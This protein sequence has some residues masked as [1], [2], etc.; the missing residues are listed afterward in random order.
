LWAKHSLSGRVEKENERFSSHFSDAFPPDDDKTNERG[1]MSYTGEWRG[2]FAERL[3]LT[4]GIRRDDNDNFQDFTTWRTAASLVLRELNARPH[5]SAGTAVKLPTMFEQ[6]GTTQFFVPNPSL[7]P[8]KS[9]G[10]DAGVELT[11]HSGRMT[12][13]VTYFRANLTDKINGFFFDPGLGNFTAINLPGE[14]TREGVEISARFKLA[15][16][17]TLGGAYTYT[18][19]RDPDGQRELRRPPHSARADVAY[20]F[21]GGRGAVTL[22]AIYNGA[23]DDRAFVLPFFTPSLRVGLDDYWLVN[24]TARYKLQPGVELF[25]RVE[26]ALDQHYQEAFGFEAAPIAA[27]AGLKLTLGGP[28]GI[29]ASRIAPE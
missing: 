20:A 9:F 28:D 10:W 17:L 13:D 22:A 2:G 12:F 16:N 11:F 23:M 6:F 5:A 1:R 4:A 25:G 18:D 29:G 8:E 14:S 24:A 27:Y 3:F 21:H 26:N 19:A 7:T 15:P